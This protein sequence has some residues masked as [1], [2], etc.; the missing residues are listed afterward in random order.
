MTE[1]TKLHVPM[2]IKFSVGSTWG[3]MS[4]LDD[5]AQEPAPSKQSDSCVGEGKVEASQHSMEVPK[6]PLQTEGVKA[7]ET[8]P[9]CTSTL[10]SNSSKKVTKTLASQPGLKTNL[11]RSAFPT[12]LKE[13]VPIGHANEKRK[14]EHLDRIDEIFNFGPNKKRILLQSMEDECLD[15]DDAIF[16]RK[17]YSFASQK[18]SSESNRPSGDVARP[19]SANTSLAEGITTTSLPTKG[20]FSSSAA[21]LERPQG[22]EGSNC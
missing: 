1:S 21:M 14:S 2:R 15:E 5:Q 11:F 20:L 16:C 9:P 10:A 18:N 22:S 7:P 17:D 4:E 8:F 13:N 6:D 3:E 19:I 12:I